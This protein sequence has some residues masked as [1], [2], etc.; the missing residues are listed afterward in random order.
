MTTLSIL[1]NFISD[2]R[3]ENLPSETM[4][5]VKMHVL[6][7]IGAMIN[8]LHSIE[9]E[10][11][12]GVAQK[13]TSPGTP[14]LAQ[15]VIASC[16]AT[17]ST[18]FDDIHLA[19]CTT[20]GSIVVPTALS[21]ANAGYLSNGKDL[22]V[23]VAVGYDSL[24]RL[25]LAVNGAAILASG[26]W[27]TYFAA[28][29]AGAATASAALKLDSGPIKSALITALALA[30]GI[31]L[32]P[33]GDLS[34]RWLTVGIAAQNGV[35]AALAAKDGFA[36]DDVFFGDVSGQFHGLPYVPGKLT[37]E[38]GI[39]FYIDETGMKPYP[40]ARQALAAV[41]AFREIVFDN[42]IMPASIETII[43]RVPKQ[44]VGIINHPRLSGN[45]LEAISSVQYQIALAAISPDDLMD[46]EHQ[47]INNDDAVVSIMDKV[48]VEPS[49]ELNPYYPL[50]WPSRVE[51][52]V[53][54]NKFNREILYPRG[55]HR[56][57]LDWNEVSAK[58]RRAASRKINQTAIDEI[59][60]LVQN[61]D[62]VHDLSSLLK[63]LRG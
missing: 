33:H 29:L 1:A 52:S 53:R 28:P 42:K 51:V 6:D 25:G 14:S 24:I 4:D 44:L 41:E 9:G 47:Q 63:L 26:I 10:A 45:R 36:A 54:D 16:A 22:I 13:T 2:L 57:K 15:S 7:T 46:M 39:R 55:D 19:S 20:P 30:S 49:P 62:S 31:V 3:F 32:H 43:I 59:I 60:H 38:V 18:E 11:L 34:M 12:V 58:F 8:G 5:N 27:P 37:E 35:T 17:R 61:L 23:A 48:Q 40:I 50:T 21:L 56:N